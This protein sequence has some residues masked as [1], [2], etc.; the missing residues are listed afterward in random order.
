MAE[1]LTLK[2]GTKLNSSPKGGIEVEVIK[3]RRVI[4]PAGNTSLNTS[5]ET[6]AVSKQEI[7]KTDKLKSILEKAG[8]NVGLI[9]TNGI[10]Y[11]DFHQETENSTPESYEIHYHLN[12][13]VKN[14]CN[15]AIIEATS[16]AFKLHRVA[17]LYFDISVFTNMGYD[18]IGD[19]EHKDFNE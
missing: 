10:H 12:E 13:M 2:L 3:K 9:G 1:K 17:D 14:K 5:S 8:Y 6:S 16:Q 15:A 19:N 7:A 18:H 4:S 11:G